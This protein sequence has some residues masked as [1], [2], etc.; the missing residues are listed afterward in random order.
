[1]PDHHDHHNRTDGF[2]WTDALID[3]ED[4]DWDYSHWD[5]AGANPRTHRT[6][7]EADAQR[8]PASDPH[9]PDCGAAVSVAGSLCPRCIETEIAQLDQKEDGTTPLG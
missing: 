8:Q 5:S 4:H 7:A 3:A 1:M 9:C 2:T 6:R